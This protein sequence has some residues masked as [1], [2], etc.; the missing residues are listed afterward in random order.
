MNNTPYYI[1]RYPTT[2]HELLDLLKMRYRLFKNSVLTAILP[3]NVAGIDMDAF[4]LQAQHLGLYECREGVETPV[5]YTRGIQQK[6]THFAKWVR[7]IAAD[8]QLNQQI[9]PYSTNAEM[10]YPTHVG[11][12]KT[13]GLYNELRADGQTI[14]ESSRHC[15]E[16]RLKNTRLDMYFVESLLAYCFTQYDN[17]FTGVAEHHVKIYARYGF[18]TVEAFDWNGHTIVLIRLHRDNL[19]PSVQP[20]VEAMAAAWCETGCICL[21]PEQRNNFYM[22]RYELTTPSV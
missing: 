1:F 10:L 2:Q 6:T 11:S 21:N 9:E 16:E 22:P 18:K 7:Q 19:A 13:T 4:D 20:R 17:A 5:G 15:M 12:A 3:D 14:C 8:N